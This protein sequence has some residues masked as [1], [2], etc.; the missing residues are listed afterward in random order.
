[1][2][3]WAHA[4]AIVDEPAEV[5]DD[6]KIWHFSHVMAGARIGARCSLGQNVFVGS[7]VSVGDGCK[8]QNNVSLY[9]GVTLAKDVFVG[10]SA[11][12]TNVVN[13]RAFIARKDEYRTTKV[14]RGAS[15]GANATVVCGVALGEYSFVGAGA[16]VTRDVPAF[17]LVTG[18][19]ARRTGWMCRCGTKL[20]AADP[21]EW[22]C[23][24]CGTLYRESK[25]KGGQLA[26]LDVAP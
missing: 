16:V 20:R 25:D 23:P 14:G 9:D 3:F 8:I 11:V 21:Y 4:S 18:V 22:T 1:M 2:A 13:P 24:K 6:T 7:Q 15:I 5:G 17:A 12:F 10:P 26:P 19:P